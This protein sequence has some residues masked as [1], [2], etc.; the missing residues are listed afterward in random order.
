MRFKDACCLVWY[1]KRGLPRRLFFSIKLLSKLGTSLV[2]LRTY[3]GKLKLIILVI[4]IHLYLSISL[5]SNICTS[6]V[7]FLLNIVVRICQTQDLRNDFLSLIGIA[8]K[9][10]INC[11]LLFAYSNVVAGRTVLLLLLTSCIELIILIF[12]NWSEM[13]ISERCIVTIHLLLFSS[14]EIW[15]VIIPLLM[16][17]IVLKVK[18]IISIWMLKTRVKIALILM[19]VWILIKGNKFGKPIFLILQI[20]NLLLQSFDFLLISIFPANT[21][22]I[23]LAVNVGILL[24]FIYWI[25]PRIFCL[26]KMLREIIKKFIR[27]MFFRFDFDSS[28]SK[29]FIRWIVTFAKVSMIRL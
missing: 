20:F 3:S 16:V 11:L 17:L 25:F 7:S 21:I 18:P 14:V 23:Y 5:T 28:A 9:K 22:G 1:S 29:F 26:G 12:I 27:Y 19:L 8:V 4:L 24:A 2:N 13:S 6:R 10:R 15:K